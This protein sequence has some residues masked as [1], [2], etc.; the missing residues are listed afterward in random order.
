MEG[1]EVRFGIANSALWATAT[2]AASNGSVNSMH[3]SFTPLGGLV[4]MWHDAARRSHL[5]RRGLRAVRHADVRHRRRVRRRP[6]GRPHAGVSRQEDRGLR[7]ED[8]VAGDLDPAGRSC[9]VG[10]AIAVADR[11]P[12]GRASSTRA[13][14]AS[15]RCC[16]PF[17]RRATTTAAPLPGWAPTRPSTTSPAGSR[18]CSPASGWR[19]RRW[20]S[21]V[22]WRQEVY[23]PP[24]PAR[25]RR[26]RRCSSSG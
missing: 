21:P 6:D 18:C 19:S 26:T 3:D 7:D 5:R 11:R 8:G 15:P 16:T 10:T 1:K 2:T 20:R 4:P 13:R 17:R 23:V 14:T 24:A 9:S 22:R 25:C 12:D